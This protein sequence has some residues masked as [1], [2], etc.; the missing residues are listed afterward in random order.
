MAKKSARRVRSGQ[1]KSQTRTKKRLQ[2]FS[3]SAKLA[4]RVHIEGWDDKKTLR[5]NYRNLG[6]CFDANQAVKPIKKNGP[7]HAPFVGLMTKSTL[8]YFF[9]IQI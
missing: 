9:M 1:T 4:R 5:E 8:F 2:H 6:I 3:N 7:E